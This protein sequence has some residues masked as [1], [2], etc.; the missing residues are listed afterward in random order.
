MMPAAVALGSAILE[1]DLIEARSLHAEWARVRA[2]RQALSESGPG[3]RAAEPGVHVPVRLPR[4][5]R[6]V[7]APVTAPYGVA[8]DAETS[9]WTFRTAIS[10]QPRPGE[11]VRSPLA[12]RVVRISPSLAGGDA[13]VLSADTDG[14]TII[15]SGLTEVGVTVGAVVRR[16]DALGRADGPAG[17]AAAGVRLEVWRG[18]VPV[19]PAALLD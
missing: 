18:R 2:A 1:R 19:D 16:G 6:P 9:A 3:P 12:A 7:A 4:L 8:R 17:A 10:F 15:V 14:W 13:V 5:L 11:P